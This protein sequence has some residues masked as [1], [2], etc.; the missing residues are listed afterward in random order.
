MVTRIEEPVSV[1][2]VYSS[3]K[4]TVYPERVYWRKRVY[5]ITKIGLHHIFREGRTLKHIFTVVSGE[6]AFRLCLDTETL[7]WVLEEISY[8]DAS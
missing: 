3:L 7:H 1:K 6:T 5:P 2:L 4:N 8:V